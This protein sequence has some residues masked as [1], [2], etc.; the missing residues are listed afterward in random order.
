[1]RFKNQASSKLERVKGVGGR[2]GRLSEGG[3]SAE[4]EIEPT[5]KDLSK[6]VKGKHGRLAGRQSLILRPT[7]LEAVLS[8]G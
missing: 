8:G 2:C 4:T 1:V 3:D 6:K 5:F 7:V